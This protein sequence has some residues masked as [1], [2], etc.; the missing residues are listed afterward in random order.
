MAIATTETTTQ[1]KTLGVEVLVLAPNVIG[2]SLFD[3]KRQP[4][5]G[6]EFYATVEKEK[7]V[8]IMSDW[9]VPGTMPMGL[10][11]LTATQRRNLR[12][13]VITEKYS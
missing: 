11:Q 12:H 1:R 13:K 3:P 10:Y 9:G 8:Q 7:V 6:E 2:L 4:V 5:E